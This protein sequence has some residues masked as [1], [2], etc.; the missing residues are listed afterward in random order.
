MS[1]LS[2]SGADVLVE[3]EDGPLRGAIFPEAVEHCCCPPAMS[4]ASEGVIN[5]TLGRGSATNAT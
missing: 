5:W 1:G 2:G 3:Y 4:L